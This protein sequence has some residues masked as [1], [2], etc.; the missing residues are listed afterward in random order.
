MNE[1]ADP[2][3]DVLDLITVKGSP[4]LRVEIRILLEKYRDAFATTLSTE[5]A[6]VPHFELEVDKEK[7]ESYS[8]RTTSRSEPRE[9]GEILK[10]VEELFR[11]GIIEPSTASYYSQVILA[12][13][14]D[15]TWEVLY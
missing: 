13:K 10:Q 11:M 2:N 4:K 9:T 15:D 8:K 5:Q 6:D 3:V 1:D 14:P 12:S 7:W